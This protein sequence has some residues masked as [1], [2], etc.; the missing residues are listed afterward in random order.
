MNDI[1]NEK[2]NTYLLKKKL[3]NYSINI[4][5]EEDITANIELSKEKT[6]LIIPNTIIEEIDETSNSS[7]RRNSLFR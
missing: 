1:D 3:L 2:L 7:R 4:S 6:L 5:I